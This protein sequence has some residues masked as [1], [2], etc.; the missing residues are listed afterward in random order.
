MNVARELEDLLDAVADAV[1]RSP[2]GARSV[3]HADNVLGVTDAQDG[4]ADLPVG[5]GE[6]L[7]QDGQDDLLP[8]P[9]RQALPEPDDPLPPLGVARVLPRGLDAVAEEVVIGR[10]GEVAGTDEVVVNVPELLD[11]VD[12]G[13]GLDG[14]LVR[15]PR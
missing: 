14:G 12:S 15:N 3:P 4:A 10:G 6:L 2:V 5:D 1:N 11:R 7:A 8:V 9:G 13:K